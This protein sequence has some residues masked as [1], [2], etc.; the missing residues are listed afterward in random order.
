MCSY[1]PSS[2]TSQRNRNSSLRQP[3]Q[4]INILHLHSHNMGPTSKCCCSGFHIRRMYSS[5]HACETMLGAW[6]NFK[7]P[8][9]RR[10]PMQPA[11]LVAWA[12]S[13]SCCLS[14]QVN[15]FNQMAC[16]KPLMSHLETYSTIEISQSFL[17]WLGLMFFGHHGQHRTCRLRTERCH[18]MSKPEKCGSYRAPL[19]S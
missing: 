18:R 10:V 11:S 7:R 14:F 8:Q 12:S 13:S 2:G 5:K 6:N 15:I 19:F 1:V 16:Q 9:P 17:F 3:C 4:E